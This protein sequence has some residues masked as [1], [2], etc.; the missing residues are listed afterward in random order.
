MVRSHLCTLNTI[1]DDPKVS[2][3]CT[4]DQGGYYIIDGSEKVVVG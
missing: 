3:E 4:Q 1:T 2:G